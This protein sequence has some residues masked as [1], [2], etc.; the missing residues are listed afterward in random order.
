M[1]GDFNPLHVD[2]EFSK[3]S[4]FGGRICTALHQRAGRL[5]SRHLHQDR[6]R[7]LEHSCRFKAPVR[8]GGTM[9]RAIEVTAK[10]TSPS[11][12]AA[13]SNWRDRRPIKRA[14]RG[15]RADPGRE[16]G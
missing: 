12:R 16:Q 8:A 6:D 4:M 3:K 7:H 1:F 5:A 2:E 9:P 10:S 13:S 11:T 15:M 14:R